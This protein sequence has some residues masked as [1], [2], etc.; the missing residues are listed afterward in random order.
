MT[1]RELV[2]RVAGL[3]GYRVEKRA[4]DRVAGRDIYEDIDVILGRKTGCLIFDLGGNEGQSVRQFQKSFRQPQIV[5]F[6]PARS[7]LEVLQKRFGADPSVRIVPCAVGETAGTGL[8]NIYERSEMN[9]LLSLESGLKAVGAELDVLETEKVEIIS[10]DD[11]TAQQGIAYIDLMK[12]D[13]QGAEMAILRGAARL[14]AE[15]RVTC[16]SL[17][18]IFGP[19]YRSQASLADYI[20]FLEPLGFRLTGFYKQVCRGHALFHCDVLFT[21][22]ENPRA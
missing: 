14:L 3:V 20:G 17:E 6:E 19:L 5:S 10:L 11:F 15:R 1:S 8:L 13:C 2:N 12:I 9:S 16:L 4:R 22:A 18:V 7:S 21:L